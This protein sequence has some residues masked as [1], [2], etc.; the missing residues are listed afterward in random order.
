MIDD[1]IADIIARQLNGTATPQD[2]AELQQWLEADAANRHEYEQMQLI[3]EKG[4][5]MHVSPTFNTTAAWSKV[6]AGIRSR[7]EKQPAMVFPLKRLA[8]AVVFLS[9]VFGGWYLWNCT[10]N[11]TQTVI[12][13]EGNM[14]VSLPDGTQVTLRKGSSIEYE[15]ELAGSFRK[16]QLKGEAFF[17]VQPM[18][19]KPFLIST[20]YSTIK[21]L[22][23]SFLVHS[24]D[25]GDEVIVSTGRVSFAGKQKEAP[26]VILSAGQK[27]VLTGNDLQ[28][29]AVSDSN[30]L[31]WKT[32][33]LSF[34]NT[35]LMEALDEIADYYGIA[36]SV[37]ADTQ[38][39]AANA[40][41]TAQFNNQ[42]ITDVLDEVKLF[43]GLETSK[44]D[45]KIIFHKK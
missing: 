14:P 17:E 28:Q 27:A 35:P 31:S 19:K 3:W 41:L 13:S 30:F 44:E 38:A 34:R 8:V 25:Q 32:G 2:L 6:D 12:A 9:A 33:V 26:Q 29:A 4:A 43:T 45:N 21:V 39:E 7:E 10:Q 36:I 18:E 11:H 42:S 37:A 20:D 22:G 1:Q 23:T 40:H 16:V 15:K 24:S 5:T